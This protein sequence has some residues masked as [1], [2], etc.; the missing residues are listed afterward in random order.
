MNIILLGY[1]GFLGSYILENL[2]QKLA[3]SYNFKIICIGRNIRNK[4]FINKK[5]RYEKWNFVNFSNLKLSFFKKKNILINCIG[6]NYSN[7]KNL[8]E[9]NLIFIQ[10]IVNYLNDNRI[11]AHLIHL[12]SVSVYDVEK[13]NLC[14]VR[15]ITE[16]SKIK[17]TNF[18]S[19]S[20]L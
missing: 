18:Y 13:K 7:S 10:K 11:L 14:K 4:P 16:N 20:K 15:N 9:I 19:E 12:S 3:E 8:K 2:H 1:N 5:I 6:K 17:F